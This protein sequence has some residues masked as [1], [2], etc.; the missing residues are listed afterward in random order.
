MLG[1]AAVSP[2]GPR[3]VEPS[4]LGEMIDLKVVD[5]TEQKILE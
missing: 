2:I 3:Q 4:G 1:S 5:L